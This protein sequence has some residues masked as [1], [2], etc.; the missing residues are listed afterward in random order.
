[1]STHRESII[2]AFHLSLE[3]W[4]NDQRPWASVLHDSLLASD[5]RLRSKGLAGFW[6]NLL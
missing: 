2:A 4:H 1:M 3:L 5:L 6:A